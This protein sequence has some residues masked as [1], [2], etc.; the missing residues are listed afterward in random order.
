[1]TAAPHHVAVVGA[2][3]AGLATARALLEAGMQPV[4]F[5]QGSQLGGVWIYT[6]ETESD[7]S[8]RGRGG[9]LHASMY[10]SL[11]TNLPRRLMAFRDFPF[12]DPDP[13]APQDAARAFPSHA[14]VLRYLQRYTESFS[15]RQHVRFETTVTRIARTNGAW[16]LATRQRA[17]GD[18][19]EQ[20]FDAIAICNGH[21]SEPRVPAL[22]GL[23]HFRGQLLHSH[24]YRS[25]EGLAAG[26]VCL[27]GAG[28]SG[29]DLALELAREG[30]EVFLSARE[31]T[32]A[33]PD[34][35]HIHLLGAL[36]SIDRD[37]VLLLE[38]GTRVTAQSLVLCTGYRYAF[39]FLDEDIVSTRDGYVS[40]LYR[41]L[42]WAPDPTLCF[43]GLPFRVI[44]FPQFAIQAE[45][46]V[47]VLD[48]RLDLP[49]AAERARWLAEHE[50]AL[51]ACA[52]P[53][54]HFL[55]HGPRQCAYYD[56][57][58]AECSAA[59]LPDWFAPLNEA[60]SQARRRDP[61][62]YRDLAD[63]AIG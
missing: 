46:W 51:L 14:A 49:G 25:P 2:G 7:A 58:A 62:G 56:E 27:L 29:I 55:E 8:G 34:E 28:P 43:V 39:P 20:T 3:A 11:R 4:V 63:T 53:K 30:R 32:T 9:R 10:R 48:G 24:N 21:Y 12:D 61:Q 41:E 59:P 17:T 54:D 26:A 37:G 13:Q 44:P 57:L 42:F 45:F 36:S 6:D 5:E 52:I 38:D 31:H 47:R 16:T 50:A 22:P 18:E 40:P 15:L 35:A 60:I 23:E 33:F 19:T 1:M